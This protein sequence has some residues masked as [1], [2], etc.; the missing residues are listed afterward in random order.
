MA[1]SE[2]PYHPDLEDLRR[3]PVDL[4]ASK[5]LPGLSSGDLGFADSSENLVF[6]LR[7]SSSSL[8]SLLD[9]SGVPL[10]SISRLHNGM[11]EL[12]KGDVEKRKELVLTAKR[13]S[14]KFSKTELKVSFA[15]ESSQHLVIKGCPFQKSCT[16]YNQDSI[17]AQLS[18]G[19]CLLMK[20]VRFSYRRV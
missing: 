10:F 1:D 15:G 8:K 12:H 3:I 17:V 13:T 5:K 20:Y 19:S 11:W 16:I 9:S 6:I 14:N 18:V 4:F 7:K 2:T